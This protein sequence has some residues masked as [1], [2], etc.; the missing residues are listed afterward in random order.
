MFRRPNVDVDHVYSKFAMMVSWT[1]HSTY[2]NDWP[3]WPKLGSWSTLCFF[4]LNSLPALWTY[5]LWIVEL[6]WTNDAIAPWKIF[7]NLIGTI[8]STGRS[9]GPTWSYE[10]LKGWSCLSE[11]EN[12]YTSRSQIKYRDKGTRISSFSLW[13]NLTRLRDSFVSFKKLTI[14]RNKT[15][16]P[17]PLIEAVQVNHCPHLHS[18]TAPVLAPH[19]EETHTRYWS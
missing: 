18:Q 11:W 3:Y 17:P 5:I 2:F 1:E 8:V 7:L 4:A 10:K 13:A 12:K 16:L 14:P 6:A 15:H 9:V 19:V